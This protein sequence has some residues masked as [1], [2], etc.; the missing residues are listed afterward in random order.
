MAGRMARVAGQLCAARRAAKRLRGYAWSENLGWINL[1]DAAIFVGTTLCQADTDGN[2]LI[3]PAD[4]SLF[5][6]LWF[7]S[8]QQ[9]LFAG[10]FDANGLVEPADVSLF[11]SRWFAA[12]ASGSC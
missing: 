9:G 3:Q 7:C 1:N 11:V 8:L 5:V 12:L 4:V 10:D 6:N 2:G